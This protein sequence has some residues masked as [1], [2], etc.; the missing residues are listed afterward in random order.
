M[1][2]RVIFA[3]DADGTLI[4]D[5]YPNVRLQKWAVQI[6]LSLKSKG[7][8]LILWTCREGAERDAVVEEC[9]RKGLIFDAVNSNLDTVTD[10]RG[11]DSRKI[12]AT[13]YLD[14]RSVPPFP[15]WLPFRDWAK[16]K[17]LL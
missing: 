5:G 8:L 9:Y 13:F 3:V 15:G 4:E 12:A 10:R 7:H 17:G 1:E 16:K 11:C 2:D 6:L 14:D